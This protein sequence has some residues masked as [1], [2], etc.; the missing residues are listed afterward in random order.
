MTPSLGDLPIASSLY[1]QE[2]INTTK[3]YKSMI[4]VRFKPMISELK[5]QALG[6][7]DT[8]VG[9]ERKHAEIL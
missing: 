4:R 3:V 9:P 7:A 6:G 5:T 1:A 8:V 2:N